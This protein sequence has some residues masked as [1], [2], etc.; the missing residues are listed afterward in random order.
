MDLERLRRIS[1]VDSASVESA[2]FDAWVS[3]K[4]VPVEIDE[5]VTLRGKVDGRTHEVM[6]TVKYKLSRVG[7]AVNIEAPDL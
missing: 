1:H 6:V 7:K 5:A 3:S 2:R 4:G